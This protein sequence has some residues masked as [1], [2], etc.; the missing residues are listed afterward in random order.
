M[1][2]LPFQYLYCLKLHLFHREQKKVQAC[3]NEWQRAMPELQWSFHHHS[4]INEKFK[5]E[6]TECDNLSTNL[7][8][9]T[10]AGN[11]Y[12]ERRNCS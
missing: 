3:R 9:W 10:W 7:P 1:Y 8:S 11:V 12:Q 4:E 6:G 2:E 5:M